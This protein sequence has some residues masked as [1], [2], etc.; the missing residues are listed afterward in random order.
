MI[1]LQKLPTLI[2]R[3]YTRGP[4]N[5]GKDGVVKGFPMSKVKR[6]SSIRQR[7]VEKTLMNINQWP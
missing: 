2:Y 6:S 4:D 3:L 7:G 5:I 1:R